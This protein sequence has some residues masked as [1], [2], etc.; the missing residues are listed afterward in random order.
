MHG[1]VPI[2]TLTLKRR[3]NLQTVTMIQNDLFCLLHFSSSFCIL[4]VPL[5]IFSPLLPGHPQ[6]LCFP[7]S[8]APFTFSTSHSSLTSL[9]LNVCFISLLDCVCV[10][11]SRALSLY[12]RFFFG[13]YRF[14]CCFSCLKNNKSKT[15]NVQVQHCSEAIEIHFWF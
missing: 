4:L 7:L 10:A 15:V 14:K 13:Y 8:S 3:F 2:S 1:H 5:P 6:P 11:M 12:F 9:T